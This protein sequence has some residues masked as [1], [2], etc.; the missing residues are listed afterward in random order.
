MARVNFVLI[1]GLMA[2]VGWLCYKMKA[3]DK[4]VGDIVDRVTNLEKL[5]LPPEKVEQT[6]AYKFPVGDSYVFGKPDAKISIMMFTNLQCG[7]CARAD[8]AIRDLVN[9]ELKDE[10]NLVMKNF[11][12]MERSKPAIKAA[13]A[14]GEQG[15]DKFWAF[16]ELAYADQRNLTD[17]NFVKWAK[18]LKLNVATFE[19][20][21]K[22]KD[23]IYEQRLNKDMEH[24]QEANINYTP[25]VL[26]NGWKY[27]GEYTAAAIRE[28]AASKK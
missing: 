19:L 14:A 20:D 18:D 11:P 24:V 16:V 27:E 1:L 9:G 22:D 12:F 5:V 26:V 25:F 3:D 7:Y 17:S 28:F 4:R 23:V 15:A 6:E 13:F 21:I 10:A 2:A 8:K